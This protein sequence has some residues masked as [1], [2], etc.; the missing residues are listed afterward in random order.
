MPCG[1]DGPKDLTAFGIFGTELQRSV[2]HSFQRKHM[3]ERLSL[4][5]SDYQ[6]AVGT[7]VLLMSESDIEIASH[8]NNPNIP[9]QGELSGGARYFKHGYP[10]TARMARL[11]PTSIFTFEYANQYG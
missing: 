11:I 4:L 2:S 9:V 3:D 6:R 1:Q 8:I 7:A 5:I 10:G